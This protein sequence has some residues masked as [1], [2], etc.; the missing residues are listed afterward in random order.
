MMPGAIMDRR[1]S[2]VRSKSPFD[3]T[4]ASYRRHR[5]QRHAH[6]RDLAGRP[7]IKTFEDCPDARN[8][9]SAR[10]MPANATRD[11]A[12]HAHQDVAGAQASRRHGL[13]RAPTTSG[14]RSN[15]ARSTAPAAGTG[16]ASSRS[17]PRWLPRHKVNVLVQVGLRAERGA[18][19]HGR[20][21]GLEVR[22]D[23][24]RPQGRRADHRPAGVPALLHRAARRLR[25]EA[26]C[27]PAQRLRRHHGGSAI[28]GGCRE[29]ASTSCRSTAPQVQDDRAEARLRRRET[30]ST[31]RG[32]RSGHRGIH[33]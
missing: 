7:P 16:R 1:C 17:V 25:R 3:P 15:A 29:D 6:L 33:A 14:S 24:G 8:R 22:E 31:R 28:P 10:A 27:D 30:S 18:H 13:S 2:T 26:T 32:A 5:Q 12:Y 4:K 23:R 11:Y 20:A 21:A 9:S 19:R